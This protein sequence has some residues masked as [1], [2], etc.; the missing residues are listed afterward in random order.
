M[1]AL[2]LEVGAAIGEQLNAVHTFDAKAGCEFVTETDR[3]SEDMVLAG[4][5]RLFPGEPVV[6]EESGSHPG[7]G[8][9]TWYVDPLDG[10]TNFAH[11]YPFFCVSIGAVDPEGL[12]LG[13]V[14]APAL[15]ECFL[16]GRDLGARLLRPRGAGESVMPRRSAVD[17]ESALLATGFPYVRDE[18]VGKN[19]EL[20]RDFLQAPC[21]GVRR[22]GSAALDLCHVGAGRLDGYWEFRLR[23]WDTAAG[24]LVARECGAIV[25]EAGGAAAIL[26]Y[27]SILAAA[28]GL[29]DKMLGIITGKGQP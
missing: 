23:P 14:C 13:A 17:L 19:T 10:T 22:A 29:Y 4:L 18:L 16:A 27:A 28:P 1:K 3:M 20:V 6:A 26:P 25:T 11:G 9:R 8:D 24:V 2:A 12:V 15:D 7:G 21:H 5:T